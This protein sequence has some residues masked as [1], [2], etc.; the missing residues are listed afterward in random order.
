[1]DTQKIKKFFSL[2]EVNSGVTWFQAVLHAL[3]WRIIA[4][5]IDGTVVYLITRQLNVA[6]AIASISAIC[7]TIGHTI[8]IKVKL[9]HIN[10][11]FY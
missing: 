2:K 3:E 10:G 4:V 7:R 6:L 11:K 9:R 8:W 5:L 1:M